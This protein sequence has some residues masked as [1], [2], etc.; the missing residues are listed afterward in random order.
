MTTN[1]Y[2]PHWLTTGEVKTEDTDKKETAEEKPEEDNDYHRSDEQVGA[3]PPHAPF[4]SCRTGRSHLQAH[5]PFPMSGW[6]E[7]TSLVT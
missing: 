4:I 1:C 5:L 2:L 6:H 7:I 3:L